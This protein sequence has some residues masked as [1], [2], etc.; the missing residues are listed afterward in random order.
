MQCN[1]FNFF[2]INGTGCWNIWQQVNGD[3]F[4]RVDSQHHDRPSCKC[5]PS[6]NVK[7]H[8]RI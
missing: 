1:Q 3:N 7:T 4:P 8:R 5:P 6:D 2:N